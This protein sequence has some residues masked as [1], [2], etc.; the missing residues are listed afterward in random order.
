[1]DFIDWLVGSAASS[2]LRL[3]LPL[4]WLLSLSARVLLRSFRAARPVAPPAAA[5]LLLPRRSW[6]LLPSARPPP[7]PLAA[8]GR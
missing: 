6:L 7:R 1:M 3:L 4:L 2:G 5:S 8:A